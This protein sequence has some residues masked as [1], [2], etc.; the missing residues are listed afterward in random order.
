MEYQVGDKFI[1]EIGEKY[2][3]AEPTENAE[4]EESPMVLYRIKGFNS[5]VFDENGLDRLIRYDSAQDAAYDDGFEA[6]ILNAKDKGYDKGLSDAW[7]YLEK[8]MDKDVEELKE[9]FDLPYIKNVI[10]V[11]NHL[12]PKEAVDKLKAWEEKHEIKVGDVII[13]NEG[14]KA[15]VQFI[16]PNGEWECLNK[17]TYFTLNKEKQ[18]LWKRTG[19]HI[20]LTEIFKGL[21]DNND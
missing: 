21:E 10:D 19:K 20:D 15:V 18:K 4:Q 1:V 5:L 14:N 9:I 2:N 11:L 13:S 12:T 8:L 6:G 16:T 7:E 3:Y 17:C